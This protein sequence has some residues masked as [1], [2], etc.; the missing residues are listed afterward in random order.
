M[1]IDEATALLRAMRR[2]APPGELSLQ[3]ILFGIKY[4]DELGG[5]N[6]ND[7]SAQ[8]GSRTLCDVQLRHGIKLAKYVELRE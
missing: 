8:M 6:L 1:T 3:A 5:V 7:L 4:H 2:K